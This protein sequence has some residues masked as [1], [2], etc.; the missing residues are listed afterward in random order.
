MY[1]YF[2]IHQNS[3]DELTM[4]FKLMTL[5]SARNFKRGLVCSGAYKEDQISFVSRDS[6]RRL[7]VV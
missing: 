1:I 4:V 7:G 3:N 2:T 6:Y 5:E